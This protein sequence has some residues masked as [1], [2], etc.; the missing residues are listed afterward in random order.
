MSE[1]LQQVSDDTFEQAVIARSR[2]VPV[3]VDF[4]AP[5][6]GPCRALGPVLEKV[7]VSYAGRVEVVKLNTDEN[8]RTAGRYQIQSIPAVKLWKDGEVVAEF[9]GALPEARV[10][11]FLDQHCPDAASQAAAEVAAAL[12]AGDRAGAET[13]LATVL[14]AGA[15]HPRAHLAQARIALADGD[16]DRAGALVDSIPLAADEF[17]A[18]RTLAGLIEL[19]REGRDGVDAT[20]AAVA[21]QPDDPGAHYRHG[22]ALASAGRYRDALDAFLAVVE[23]DKRWN[24]EAGRKAMLA[25]FAVLGV[26]HPVSD[27]YRR[28]LGLLL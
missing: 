17:A 11:A 6:C 10:R 23:R 7:A 26:R 18:A 14:A 28:K 12:A 1:Q 20:A 25:V 22:C 8:Q 9:V 5:W 27:Q 3:L 13:A 21:A 16:P 19:A 24:D 15:D 2:Q 4:W